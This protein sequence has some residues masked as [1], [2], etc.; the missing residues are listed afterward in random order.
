M[1]QLRTTN[2]RHKRALTARQAPR[3][4]VQDSK[5]AATPSKEKA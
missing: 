2:K 3:K 4:P 5:E 1:G